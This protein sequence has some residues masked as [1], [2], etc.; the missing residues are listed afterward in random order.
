MC[1][2][3]SMVSTTRQQR[4]SPVA[5][6]ATAFGKGNIPTLVDR[7]SSQRE[8][9]PYVKGLFE[10]AL[11]AR[12]SVEAGASINSLSNLSLGGGAVWLELLARYTEVA[13]VGELAVAALRHLNE[14][15]ALYRLA[16][17]GNPERADEVN[18]AIGIAACK[19]Y[20]NREPDYIYVH[21]TAQGLRYNSEFKAVRYAA[22][23]AYSSTD[24]TQRGYRSQPPFV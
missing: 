24:P 6:T 13:G 10:C 9:A 7:L 4:G 19:A 16:M 11:A 23:A 2:E 8:L 15:E 12:T 14:F 22:H 18:Q 21:M 20:C 5:T 1:A 17:V 3:S